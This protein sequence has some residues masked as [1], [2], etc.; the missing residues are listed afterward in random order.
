MQNELA[1]MLKGLSK[2]QLSLIYTR[3]PRWWE[4]SIEPPTPIPVNV[5]YVCDKTLGSPSTANC[6]AAL[7]EF[8]Q[9]GNV[10][11][12]PMS[13][14]II[15]V[16]GKPPDTRFSL[17]GGAHSPSF[18]GNCAISVGANERHST[19]WDMLR[20]VAETLVSTCI[21]SPVSGA[22]GGTAISQTMPG[23]KRSSRFLGR[24][25]TGKTSFRRQFLRED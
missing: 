22:V 7:Y 16:T 23:Q 18:P 14:P 13:G 17:Q 3:H 11:L 24:S 9:S 21:S 1:R 10:I 2:N 4:Y 6:E 15:K 25:Q 20:S 12:D 19:T 5:D 8:V